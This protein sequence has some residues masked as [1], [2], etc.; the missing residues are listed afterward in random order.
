M[1]L[2]QIY[3]CNAIAPYR[4]IY[5]YI[6]LA[7]QHAIPAGTCP[8]PVCPYIPYLVFIEFQFSFVSVVFKDTIMIGFIYEVTM[9]LHW[10]RLPIDTPCSE[11][12]DADSRI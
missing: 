3:I 4:R 6:T 1:K 11:N 10:S 8:E 7:Y 5:G 12:P 9:P 2:P